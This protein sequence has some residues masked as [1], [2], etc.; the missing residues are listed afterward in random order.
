MCGIAGIV[1]ANNSNLSSLIERMVLVLRLRG[2]DDYGFWIEANRG[3]ALGH[4]RLAILDLSSAGRQPMKSRSGRYVITYNGEIYNYLEVRDELIKQ[5]V[6][7]SGHSDTEVMLAAFEE[8]GIV[9]SVK[10]FDGMFAFAVW[11]NRE[12]KLYL[13]RDRFGE[14]PLYYGWVDDTLIFGSELKAMREYKLWR[15]KIEK[16][17][18]SL[19][20]R[21]SYIP[22]PYSIYENVF[23]L[24][25]GT[26]L[27]V[28]ADKQEKQYV[29]WSAQEVARQAAEKNLLLS[30]TE[31]VDILHKHLSQ[32]VQSRCISDVPLGIFLSGGIDSS[33]ITSL[34]QECSKQPVKT[35]TIGFH[36]KYFNNEAP[37]AKDIAHHLGTDH[38]EFY[39]TERDAYEIIPRLP[40]LYDEPFADSSQIPTHLL[41]M[42]ARK[43]VTVC[44]SGDGGDELFG[45]YNRYIWLDKIYRKFA[46][47]PQILWY[48]LAGIKEEWLDAANRV[49]FKRLPLG[50]Q[51]AS[52]GHKINKISRAFQHTKTSADFYQN[53]C[54]TINNPLDFLLDKEGL[55]L[56]NK[57]SNNDWERNNDFVH[58]MM[59]MDTTSYLPGDILTKV[60]RAAMGASLEVRAPFL[61]PEVFYYA[62]GLP[63]DYKVR[64]KC[65]KY[66]LKKLLYRYVPQQLMERP[67]VG[68][69]V[70]I[71]QWLKGPLHGWVSDL[72]D[73]VKLQQQGFFNA[74]AVH[75]CWQQH[76][77][78]SHDWTYLLWNFL[79]FQ[80]WLGENK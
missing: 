20:L 71:G 60:D 24:I 57:I 80:A 76:L 16:R 38:T 77:T 11:D 78:G 19:F 4:C 61:D 35:F 65:S 18:L 9:K 43:T 36:E 62:W 63:L 45:G 33:L 56:D 53:I 64:G 41:S 29:Y 49:V 28:T 10:H 74:Q 69:G 34:A 66:I 1:F 13:G 30:E 39:V 67:K 21:Y 31:A 79:V 40:V 42:L 52:L 37:Y 6:N 22:A 46:C 32:S 27:E 14:K 17:A 3:I 44:L 12:Y 51:I 47:C 7:F 50:M 59:L 48:L 70:P 26:V 2:P 58:W 73:M 23:K 8:W 72:L 15:P 55:V 25:P 75:K 54:S 68:F 5:G